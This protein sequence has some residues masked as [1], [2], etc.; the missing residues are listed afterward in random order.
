M[1]ITNLPIFQ[2]KKKYDKNGWVKITNLISEIEASH[3]KNVINSYLQKRD[4]KFDKR[5]ANFIKINNKEI[6]HTFHKISHSKE[7][8]KFATQKIF[9]SIAE[10]LINNKAKFRKCELF[11]KPSKFGLQSPP[12]QDNYYW[13]LK[14]G[15]SLTFWIALD[16]SSKKNGGI[17][18]YNGSHK[19][20]L[21]P[22]ED[23]NIMG[24][25]QKVKNIKI[26]KKLKKKTPSLKI[27]D[28]LIHDSQT[29]HGSNKNI[30]NKNRMGLTIQFQ[31]INCKIDKKKQLAYLASLK[32]Q[33]KKRL[34][35][36]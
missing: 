18:Y 8:K 1:K 35:K 16:Q 4:L 34:D 17:Y 26:V 15:K 29:I 6:I 23:S 36:I 24:S 11:A 21:V 33:I 3:I 5:N 7:I 13:C 14:G 9:F 12:H 22:H 31:S 19:I 27:G 30:S 32:N 2:L 20:G 28:V 25:S 10:N